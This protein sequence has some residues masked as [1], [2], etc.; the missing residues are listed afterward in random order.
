MLAAQVLTKG[1]HNASQSAKIK[2]FVQ[3]VMFLHPNKPV[4][5]V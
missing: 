1:K 3:I 5:S 2:L 4:P